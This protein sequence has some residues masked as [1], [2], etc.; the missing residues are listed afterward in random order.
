MSPSEEQ[1]EID[2][3]AA[4]RLAARGAS[5]KPDKQDPDVVL[6][7]AREV[8][9]YLRGRVREVEAMH[10][11]RLDEKHKAEDRT[12]AAE[13]VVADLKKK[14]DGFASAHQ[15]EVRELRAQNAALAQK[16][17]RLVFDV[18]AFRENTRKL[19][20][21]IARE[22]SPIPN[23]A[24]GPFSYEVVDVDRIEKHRGR[25]YG[26]LRATVEERNRLR[27][28]I[29]EALKIVRKPLPERNWIDLDQTLEPTDF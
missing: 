2:M 27:A 28:R 13:A 17:E 9:H 5:G 25:A 10:D 18:D 19:E 24:D 29:A 22:N 20:E 15:A 16:A 12:V 7:K 8:I 11:R 6:A 3:T 26:R 14:L 4:I 1:F 21:Q 23:V